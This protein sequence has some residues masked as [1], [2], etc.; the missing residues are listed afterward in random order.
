MT[1][2]T[3]QELLNQPKGLG[4]AKLTANQLSVPELVQSLLEINPPQRV[5]AFRLLDKDKAIAVFEMLSPE[6]QVDLIREMAD[7]E[8]LP[9]LEA[10]DP[11]QRVRLFEELPAKVTKRLLSQ[12]RPTSREAVDLLLGYPEGSVGRR[13]NLRYLAV[14]EGSKVSAVLASV[15]ESQ[16][17]DNELDLVFIL[18]QQGVYRGFV[19]TVRLIKANPELLIEQLADGRDIAISATAPEMQ[20]ARLLKDYDLPAIPVLDGEGRLVGDITFDDV[21]DLIEEEASSAALAQA[22][23]G[24]Y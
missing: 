20:A 17:G 5:L 24:G 2:N 1:Y 13:M 18:D 14:R 3:L 9:I 16:L 8:I 10:L 11:E 4:A 15:R 7:P 21:I 19:R 6:Q 12:L 22:G 23:V